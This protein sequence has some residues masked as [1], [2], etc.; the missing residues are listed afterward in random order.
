MPNL[1]VK[2]IPEDVYRRLK[3]QARKHHRSLNQEIIA[4][5]EQSTFSVPMDPAVFLSQAREIRKHIRGALLTEKRLRQLKT[6]GRL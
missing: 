4:C 3:T 5:L 1:T 2:N 6:A